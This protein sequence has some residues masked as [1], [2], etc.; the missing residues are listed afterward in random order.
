MKSIE[1]FEIRRILKDQPNDNGFNTYAQISTATEYVRWIKHLQ[2]Y[3][4]Y[5]THEHCGGEIWVHLLCKEGLTTI[6]SFNKT[7]LV[8]L[9]TLVTSEVILSA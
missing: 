9:R 6:N 2:Q 5:A 1:C 8:P 4:S 7:H 3:N